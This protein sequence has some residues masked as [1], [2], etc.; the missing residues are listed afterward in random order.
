[1][2]A[3]ACQHLDPRI[4]QLVGVLKLVDQD[5]AKTALVVLANGVV[6]AQHL[7]AA[8]HQF[9][10]INHAFALAL[11]FI[12]LVDLNLFTGFFVAHFHHIRAQPIFLAATNEPLHLFG[13]KALVINAKLLVQALDA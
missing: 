6:V 10:K 12:Q 1:V 4:L 8:Q 13:R 5:V 9:A 3:G 2:R 11:V 7:K